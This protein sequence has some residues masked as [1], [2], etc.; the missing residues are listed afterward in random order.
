[1]ADKRSILSA[2]GVLAETNGNAK[3]P[4]PK[5]LKTSNQIFGPKSDQI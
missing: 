5:G 4:M 3:V 1:M 2:K